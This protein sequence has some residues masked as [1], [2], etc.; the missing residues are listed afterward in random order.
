MSEPRTAAKVGDLIN[1]RMSSRANGDA[2]DVGSRSAEHGGCVPIYGLASAEP[3]SSEA[4][5]RSSGRGKGAIGKNRRD[6]RKQFI[7]ATG[8]DRRR[9]R[10][11]SVIRSAI[12]SVIDFINRKLLRI[13]DARGACLTTMAAESKTDRALKDIERG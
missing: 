5:E 2:F 6:P 8:Q 7:I 4:R 9:P 3:R 11:A 10:G 1:D 12:S 13:P